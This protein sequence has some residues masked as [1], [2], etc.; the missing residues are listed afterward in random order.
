MLD[1][2]GVAQFTCLA[3]LSFGS[4][5]LLAP[6]Q[7]YK[8]HPFHR[9]VTSKPCH[10]SQQLSTHISFWGAL[11]LG[12]EATVS[13]TAPSQ[14]L[15]AQRLARHRL[16]IRQP[17]ILRD[18]RIRRPRRASAATEYWCGVCVGV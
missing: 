14:R 8:F 9:R 6:F 1:K 18:P 16:G 5:I 10:A 12:A 17:Q 7:T 2:G 4:N 13:R 15:P 3:G 11:P